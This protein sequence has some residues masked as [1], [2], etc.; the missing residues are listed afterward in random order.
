MTTG[1]APAGQAG[2]Q[3]VDRAAA[4]LALV[5]ESPRPRTFTSLVEE[6]GLAKSTTSRLLQALERHRLLQRD[7]SGAFRAGALFAFYAARHDG[8][9]DL[10]ELAHPTLER[11][12]ERTGETVNLGLPRGGAVIQVAQV[13]SRYLLGTTNWVGMSV[14]AH[15]TALGKVFYAC[16]ALTLPGHELERRTPQSITS[17]AE[18]QRQLEIGARRGWAVAKEE[19]EPELVAIA[20]PVYGADGLVIAAVSVS[21]PT[22]RI[23][24]RRTAQIG[25]LLV[26]ETRHLSSQLGYQPGKEGVA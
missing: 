10:V 15:C 5:V 13:E 4:L 6:L 9:D 11:L 25:S 17:I 23:D 21:G 2:T 8:P 26:D 20:A 7:R 14:P 16:G 12:G 18:L 24:E 1:M 19:L 3:A 22:A